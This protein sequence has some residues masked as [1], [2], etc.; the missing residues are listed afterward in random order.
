MPLFCL[1]AHVKSFS[2]APHITAFDE[3]ILGSGSFVELLTQGDS[4]RVQSR[5]PLALDALLDKVC[6]VTGLDA[7]RLQ[8]PGKERDVAR[9]RAIFCCLAVREYGYSATESGKAIGLGSAGASI[10]VRRGGELL[11]YNPA[12]RDEI[13]R[14]AS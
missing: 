10:A 2:S 4:L 9:T 6:T 13:V 11:K 12:L 14:K 7:E 8:Y 5:A 1:G 3:R